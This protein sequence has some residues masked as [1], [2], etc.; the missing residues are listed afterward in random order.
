MVHV[1]LLDALVGRGVHVMADDGRPGDHPTQALRQRGTGLEVLENPV[2]C[3]P[4]LLGQVG[5]PQRDDREH[6]LTRSLGAFADQTW[7]DHGRP[8]GVELLDPQLR[9]RLAE[10]VEVGGSLLDQGEIGRRQRFAA[11]FINHNELGACSVLRETSLEQVLADDAGI[12]AGKEA[13][14]VV[15]GHLIPGRRVPK[16]QKS[17]NRPGQHHEPGVT[18]DQPG[19]E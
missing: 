10:L 1:V 16:K 17:H 19:K 18:L 15:L 9:V 14:V 7:S 4:R 8:V 5:T 2:H 6:R 3:D 13:D 11:S 12:V